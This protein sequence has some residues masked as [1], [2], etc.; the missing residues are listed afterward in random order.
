MGSLECWRIWYAAWAD[1]V[2]D[3]IAFQISRCGIVVMEVLENLIVCNHC[4]RG[5]D[6]PESTIIVLDPGMVS[7]LGGLSDVVCVRFS[8]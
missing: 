8:G 3:F 7:R 5:I 6:A 4:A 2:E 1:V